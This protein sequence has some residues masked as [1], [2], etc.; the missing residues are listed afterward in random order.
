MSKYQREFMYERILQY[1]GNHSKLRLENSASIYEL[2]KI[3]LTDDP[4]AFPEFDDLN[5]AATQISNLLKSK[6]PDVE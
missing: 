5:A 6:S 1:F 4:K 2:A 3:A